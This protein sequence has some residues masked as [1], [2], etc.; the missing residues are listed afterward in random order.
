MIRQSQA[1][2]HTAAS[3]STVITEQLICEFVGSMQLR[4]CRPDSVKKY[5]HD[6]SSLYDFLPGE[7]RIGRNTLR[8]WRAALAGEGYA[9]RTINAA[10]SVAN[11]FLAWLGLREYQLPGQLSIRGDTQPALTRN[12]YLRLLSAARALGRERAYL[13][14]KVFAA[15]GLTVQELQQLTTKTV[16]DG[17][18][19][20]TANGSGRLVQ[21]PACLRNE[22]LDY[23]GR[24]GAQDGPVFITRNGKTLNRT[25]VTAEI[26]NLAHAAQVDSQKCNPRCLRKLYQAT[27]GEIKGS[28]HVLVAQA[29]E[30]LLEQE[31]LTVGWGT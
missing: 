17:R 5:R 26:Q 8:E 29:Y 31:Q 16:R 27:M 19:T 12:E 20:V 24:I 25:T 14:T 21:I 23:A 1:E 22:L 2:V 30:H 15:L 9:P 6:L 4:G 11:S 18:L 7:K 13:L 28:M 3:G 10:V